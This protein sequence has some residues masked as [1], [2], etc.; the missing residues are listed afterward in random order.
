MYARAVASSQGWQWVV[1]GF[2][3][4]RR[5]PFMWI[6]FTLVLAL[7]WMLSFA[8]PII[9][10]LIFNLLSPVFFAGLML[11]C[12]TLEQGEDLELGHLFSG[13]RTRAAAL[14]TVGGVHLVGSIIIVGVFYAAAGGASLNTVISAGRLP[15]EA[16][17]NIMLGLLMSLALYTPLLMLI[18]FAPLLVIF[19]DFAPVAAMRAS[20][21]ACCKNIMPFLLYSLVLLLFFIAAIPLLIGLLILMPIVFC[22]IYA[23]YTDI[24]VREQRAVPGPAVG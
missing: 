5:S 24:F 16:A 1:N 11:G 8:I 7:I 3:L 23:S 22:S 19:D 2:R 9:G 13:F 10:P 21:I 15:R 4:F 20:F 17:L 6:A 14:V 18:W 12:R